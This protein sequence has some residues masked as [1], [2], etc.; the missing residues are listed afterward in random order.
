MAPDDRN[1]KAALDHVWHHFD[2]H[3]GQRMS[4][5]NFYLV[6]SHA[7]K[8]ARG[9]LLTDGRAVGAQRSSRASGAGRDDRLFAPVCAT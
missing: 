9:S 5:F 8:I 1:E 4:L 7:A 6:T 3:A 2:L